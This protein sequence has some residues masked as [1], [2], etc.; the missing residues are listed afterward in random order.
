MNQHQLALGS[1][2]PPRVTIQGV[3]FISANKVDMTFLNKR[4]E[5]SEIKE[6]VA[7]EYSRAATELPKI[8]H[9]LNMTAWWLHQ[10]TTY[11]YYDLLH[12][13]IF[14][15]YKAI[16]DGEVSGSDISDGA[17]RYIRREMLRE[18]AP[19]WAP[20]HQQLIDYAYKDGRTL[21]QQE[22]ST[23]NNKRNVLA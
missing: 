1:L 23:A 3:P 2:A 15:S 9:W 10:A 19:A 11:R 6:I 17:K 5:W 16:K 4:R 12:A 14:A 21:R 13:G 18:A 22:T 20:Y 7:S 8:R